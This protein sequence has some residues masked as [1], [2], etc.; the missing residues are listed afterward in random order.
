MLIRV[1]R[2]G[3]YAE[4][5]RGFRREI[6]RR[7]LVD[8]NGPGIHPLAHAIY[9][10]GFADETEAPVG[11]AEFSFYDDAFDTYSKAV[12]SQACDLAEIAP[13]HRMAHVRSVIIDEEHRNSRLF[14][15]LCATLVETAY[16]LGARYMTA[17]TSTSYNYI[18]GLHKNAGMRRLGVFDLD[19][20]AQQLSLLD[21]EPVALRA[22]RLRRRQAPWIGPEIRQEFDRRAA[23]GQPTYEINSL[24]WETSNRVLA[25]I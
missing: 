5:I 1:T 16:D 20:S 19:G 3:Q 25:A 6:C 23:M 15:Y 17:S 4:A 9:V 2:A 22:R 13:M 7:I 8:P 12:Y 21:L 24:E 14:M 10:L 18:L 11:M